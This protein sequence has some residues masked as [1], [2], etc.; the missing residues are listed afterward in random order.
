MTNAQILAAVSQAVNDPTFKKRGKD[1]MLGILTDSMNY[2]IDRTECLRKVDSSKS[3][4]ASV[5]ETAVPSTF[6]KFPMEEN[7]VDRGFV[8]VGTNA[9]Y[10]LTPITLSLLNNRFPNWRGATAGTPQFYY[11]T[12]EGSPKIGLY[13]APSSTF[14]TTNGS[15]IYMDII[16]RASDLVEDSNLP[17]DNSNVYKGM[18]QIALKLRSIWQI[19]LED[20]QFA[21]AD[22][23]NLNV[24][25]L[26]QLCTDFVTSMHVAVG[27]HGFEEQLR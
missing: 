17:F 11:L 18:F 22:R 6:I 20:M 12:K 7:D 16:Y 10:P 19:K 13:P 21:D 25:N 4:T 1:I 9:K 23:L 8:A 27:Q 24:E 2:I 15:P 14:I 5:I 26:I 3:M